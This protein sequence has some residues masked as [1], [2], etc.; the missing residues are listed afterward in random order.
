M[1]NRPRWFLLTLG[2][3]IV[4]TLFTFPTWRKFF[5]ARPASSADFANISDNQR[6]L[7]LQLRRTPSAVP[8][9]AQTVYAA[10]IVT[11]LAP[12]SDAATPDSTNAQPIRSGDFITID[13]I[14]TAQG[15]ATLYRLTDNSLLL[16]FDNFSVT[17]GPGLTV[18]L[19]AAAAPLTADDLAT[20]QVQLKLGALKG[21]S[22]S[23]NYTR[24]P[25]ELDLTRYKS[26]VIYSESLKTVYSSAVLG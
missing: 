4:L 25:P 8:Q 9:I 10:M 5:S 16:R 21:T 1:R 24:L 17:N 14:H 2:A 15:T 11:V 13:P 19:S 6:S 20:G 18:Y 23:Q 12:T 22:G 7:L 3:L 26:V